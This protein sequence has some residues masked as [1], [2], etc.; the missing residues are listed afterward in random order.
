MMFDEKYKL[1]PIAAVINFVKG[2]KELILPFAII[3]LTNGFNFSSDR[4]I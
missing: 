4:S 2:L 1:H 3:I